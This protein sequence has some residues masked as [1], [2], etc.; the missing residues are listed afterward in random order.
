[1]TGF[2]AKVAVAVIVA[3]AIWCSGHS[4]THTPKAAVH[5]TTVHHTTARKAKR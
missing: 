1:V 3:A 2:L 5:A 4:A